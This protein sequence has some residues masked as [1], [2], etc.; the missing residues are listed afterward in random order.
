MEEVDSIIIH[1]LKQIGCDI[2]SEIVSIRELSVELVIQASVKCLQAINSQCNISSVFP[3]NMSA[4]F[5]I[6]T[7]IA[8]ACQELGYHGEL[9]YQTFLYANEQEFRKVILFLIEKLPKDTA[10][11]VSEP[12]GRSTLLNHSIAAE[13][14]RQLSVPWL[15]S[16]C[17]KNNL[18][19]V[20][21]AYWFFQGNS[22]FH[23]LHTEKLSYPFGLTKLLSKGQKACF[24]NMKFVTS[25]TKDF[26]NNF[27]SLIDDN[28]KMFEK[29]KECEN[30]WH[31]ID[32][33]AKI[34]KDEHLQ[35][36]K[37]RLLKKI[38]QSFCTQ[39]NVTA[40]KNT[41]KNADILKEV[42]D[43]LPGAEKKSIIKG[44]RFT[45]AEKLHFTKEEKN[46][47][48]LTQ[49][50][51]ELKDE[52]SEEEKQQKQASELQMLQN[53][54]NRLV[55]KFQDDQLEIRQ[56]TAQNNQILDNTA[57]L[58]EESKIQET[59]YR[60]KKNTIDLLPD[61]KTNISKLEQLVENSSQ[62]LINLN[63]QW[64]KHRVRLL[65]NYRNLK[66]KQKT[67]ASE[68]ETKINKIQVLRE[69]IKLISQETRDKEELLKHFI[70][71]Y[72]RLPKDVNRSVYTK[73][74]LEIVANIKKQK[75]QISNVLIDTRSLQKDINFLSG[76]LDRTFTVTDEL[77][78]K[79]ATKDEFSKKSY[80]LLAA[81]HE[82]FANLIKT[83][84][85]TGTVLR[86]IRDL[87]EQIDKFNDNEIEENLQKLR[88]DLSQ[89]KKENDE[90]IAK[91][92]VIK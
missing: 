47:V 48:E 52:V 25:Q 77:V 22:S 7:S 19:N 44:S 14:K 53:E 40:N 38:K 29:E 12:I 17:R 24:S 41:N 20:G 5:R 13:L 43:T 81:I 82:N 89:M 36:K 15:P 71:E 4:R 49:R 26:R 66:T 55:L 8:T 78:F 37:E 86:E 50:K 92:K 69:K 90:M 79:N 88:N 9:G 45:H 1:T 84:E 46:L 74:I 2:P 63:E 85:E 83:V 72:E 27:A 59:E 73:R 62:R 64:E 68:M 33:S 18:V 23:P 21:D 11:T 75:L 30:E 67:R 56:M 60:I 3:E 76:N 80:K 58:E 6:G 51:Q 42:L 61:A 10:E 39:L 91:L 54:L 87:E 35:K 57:I 34:S 70:S 32:M 16:Y 65:E 28:T 31:Q